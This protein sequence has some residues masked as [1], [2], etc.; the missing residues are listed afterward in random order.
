[1]LFR[2]ENGETTSEGAIRETIEEAGARIELGEPYSIIDVPHV[3]QVHMFF[4]ARLQDPQ[5]DP[6]LESLEAR[7][8]EEHQIPWDEI[9]FRTV[10]QTLRWFLEDRRSDS[11]QLHTT[12][13]RYA[14]RPAPG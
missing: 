10:S 12:T 13:I 5:F 7:L 2:S 14:P 8:F 3:E 6:G 9:A 11:F 4:L 1:M